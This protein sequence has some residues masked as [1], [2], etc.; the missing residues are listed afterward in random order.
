[1]IK[2]SFLNLFRRKS[3]TFLTLLAIAVGVASIIVLVSIVDGVV[4]DFT[5]VFEQFQ[6]IM[7]LEKGASDTP[8]SKIDRS[9]EAKLE[10]I[11]GVKVA[12]PEIWVLPN[13]IDGKIPEFSLSTVMV[14]GLDIDKYLVS[15]GT[16]WIADVEKGSFIKNSDTDGVVIGKKIAE[17]YK[18]FIGSVIDIDG[19]KFRV[20]GIFSGQSEFIEGV[21]VMPLDSARELTTLDADK[22]NSFTIGLT[23]PTKDKEIAEK[24][25]FI[26][27]DDLQ[28][29][30]MSQYSEEFSSIFGSL[31]LLVWAIAAIAAIVAGVGIINTILMSILD[32]TAEIGTLKATGWTNE[33]VFI[34]IMYEALSIGILGG[35][36]GMILGF[37]IDLFLASLLNIN[38]LITFPLLL[39]AFLFALFIGLIA[40]IYPAYRAV[41]LDPI[42]AIRSG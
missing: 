13:K 9:F 37:A 22:V 40:G 35:I 2:L 12:I 1:M 21:I 34:M 5:E 4:A 3:R 24:I 29:L 20:K 8:F 42:E 39:Q 19:K 26:Y 30:S 38:F 10:K 28:A 33:N 32:R 41:K 7:V 18:K 23:D 15:S 17:D 11:N 16:G 25:E 31:R 14:Y 6:G 27:S 36:I